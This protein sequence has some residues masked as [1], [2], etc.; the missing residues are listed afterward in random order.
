M[1]AASFQNQLR[2]SRNQF[3]LRMQKTR[4]NH[5]G[6]HWW[7]WNESEMKTRVRRQKSRDDESS[8]SHFSVGRSRDDVK[9]V[10]HA[11]HIHVWWDNS[12]L[13]CCVFR[14]QTPQRDMFILLRWYWFQ[15]VHKKLMNFAAI[16]TSLHQNYRALLWVYFFLFSLIRLAPR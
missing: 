4:K 11:V 15:Y 16:W 13:L 8:S 7:P 1:L 12:R 9:S 3:K 6:L 10:T 5:G 14:L 2:W